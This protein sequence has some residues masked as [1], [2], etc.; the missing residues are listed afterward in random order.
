MGSG[1]SQTYGPEL[2][3]AQVPSKLGSCIRILPQGVP[4]A[5]M[6]SPSQSQA[7]SSHKAQA[8]FPKELSESYQE[9]PQGT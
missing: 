4:C 2:A 1:K 3:E 9:G 6:S 8:G 7:S 5:A